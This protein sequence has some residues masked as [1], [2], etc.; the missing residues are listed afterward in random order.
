MKKTIQ[1]LGLFILVI[2]L[3]CNKNNLNNKFEYESSKTQQVFTLLNDIEEVDSLIYI[4]G[5][6][7]NQYLDEVYKK[8]INTDSFSFESRIDILKD[9][10]KNVF[11]LE[12][13]EMNICFSEF[14][15]F[16]EYQDII[17]YLNKI[18]NKFRNKNYYFIFEEYLFEI[19][20]LN[21]FNQ[22]STL[23]L[24][25]YNEYIESIP[26]NEK[27]EFKVSVGILLG[28]YEYWL[29]NFDNW[30]T[31]I[32]LNHN[33][34]YSTNGGNGGNG[35]NDD[36]DKIDDKD[37]DNDKVAKKYIRNFIRSDVSGAGLGATVGSAV[38]A[39]GTAIGAIT[40]GAIA[41]GLEATF[42]DLG[43]DNDGGGEEK[44]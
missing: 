42:A 22:F 44:D 41:S 5:L 3:S 14:N 21:D 27:E 32:N 25:Y 29:R 13:N 40:F 28:S 38:P 2:T 24:N 15:N 12:D 10:L 6:L 36:K 7:H 19:I 34:L 31:I 33:I 9:Q 8:L 23:V 35:G 26:I 30:K 39:I 11:N 43:E 1:I 4:S 18:D 16:E 37:L 20:E 17:M